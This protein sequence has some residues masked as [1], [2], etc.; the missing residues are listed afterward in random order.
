MLALNMNA[1]SKI[2]C[3]QKNEVMQIAIVAQANS[4]V[5]ETHTT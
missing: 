5:G 1:Y 3:I 2:N 4:K